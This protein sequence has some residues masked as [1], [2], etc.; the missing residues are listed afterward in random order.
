M[1][2]SSIGEIVVIDAITPTR[3]LPTSLSGLPHA[4]SVP[5]AIATHLH[6]QD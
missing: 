5:E 2:L 3:S 6:I 4:Y 1:D